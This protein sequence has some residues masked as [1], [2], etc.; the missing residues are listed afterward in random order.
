[1]VWNAISMRLQPPG[2]FIAHKEY[3]HGKNAPEIGTGF[4]I[5]ELRRI[6]MQLNPSLVWVTQ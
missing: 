2:R 3:S 6:D 5:M 4:H 1:M